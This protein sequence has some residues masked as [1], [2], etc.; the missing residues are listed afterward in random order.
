MITACHM[1]CAG[2]FFLEDCGILYIYICK[3]ILYIHTNICLCTIYM[4]TC[5]TG[6]LDN[7][8]REKNETSWTSILSKKKWKKLD[9]TKGQEERL[10]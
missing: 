6:S 1:T 5:D 10:K 4:H 8:Y 7:Y 2:L 9:T 3:Y